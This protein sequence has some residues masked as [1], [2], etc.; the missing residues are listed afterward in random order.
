MKLSQRQQHFAVNVS[1][2][3]MRANRLRIGLTFGAVWRNNERLKCPKCKTRH[4]LQE[5]LFFNGRSKI[6][7]GGKHA[8]RLAIDLIVW[9]N[10]KPCWDGEPYR[11]LGEFW[12]SLGE[13]WGGRF[14]VKKKDY[15]VKVGWDPGHFEGL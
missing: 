2:L 15:D 7:R 8:Q 1:L 14:G 4:S 5:L 13:R 9:R 6:K 3:L 10:G 12:E 11:M